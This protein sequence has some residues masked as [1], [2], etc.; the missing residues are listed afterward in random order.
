MTEFELVLD[1]LSRTITE[2]AIEANLRRKAED[3][4]AQ[5]QVAGSQPS[6][7]DVIEML[8]SMATGKKIEAIKLCR[9]LTGCGLKEAK[10]MIENA[11]SPRNDR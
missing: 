2:L 8:A 11:Q 9:L 10:D 4:V 5:L 6:A 7:R 3:T 1:R